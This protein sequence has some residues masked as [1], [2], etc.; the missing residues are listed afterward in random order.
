MLVFLLAALLMI[1]ASSTYR[2]YQPQVEGLGSNVLQWAQYLV[3]GW[4]AVSFLFFGTAELLQ[5]ISKPFDPKKR[6]FLTESVTQGLIVGTTLASI[7]GFLDAKAGPEI[8]S[9]EIKL[10]TLPDSFKGLVL[11]QISDVHIGPL[12]HRSFL[13]QV[14]DR[15]MSLNP[16]LILITGDLVDGTVS[17]LQDQMGA[18]KRLKAKEGIYFCTGNHEYYS[19]VEEWVAYLQSIGVQVLQNSNVIFKR[20]GPSGVEEKLMLAGVP[21]FRASP[22]TAHEYNPK[23][24][25]ETQ[26]PIGCKILISHN[27]HGIESAAE[28][29]F[30]FQLSG[31]THAGQFMPFTFF[32]KLFLKHT[33]GH[34]QINETTQLYV[35]RGT[36][37]WGPPNRLGKRAEITKITLV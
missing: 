34:Y 37:Y 17:Q 2:Y 13:D 4:L 7:S 24:A 1:V 20:T 22:G 29:G 15:V 14:V 27:P 10:P 19:G 31:H 11:A 32:M 35:N 6:I 26:E 30:H 9:V 5:L 28:A 16:D 8:H 12:L 3:M 25:A 33:E 21:D 18:L 36:G 23:K